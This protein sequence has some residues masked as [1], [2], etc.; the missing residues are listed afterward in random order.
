[1]AEGTKLGI[2]ARIVQALGGVTEDQLTAERTAGYWS[3][4]REA[5]EM[6]GEDEPV[7]FTSD[8]KP[9]GLGYKQ[10][11]KEPRDLSGIS[12]ERANS[13]AYR[14]WNTH[15]LAKAIIEILVDYI[16][17]DGPTFQYESE[18]V[19]EAL[20]EFWNDPVNDMDGGLESFVRE[21]SLFGEQLFL[22][23]VQDGT[24]IG[25]VLDGRLR[26]GPVDPNQ[27]AAIVTHPQNKRQMLAVRL[28]DENGDLENGPLFKLITA[29]DASGALQ[30][31]RDL[32]EYRQL[33]NT[34]EKHGEKGHNVRVTEG[35]IE[36][37]GITRR[38][39][40]GQ[41]WRLV[42]Q[43]SG[44]AKMVKAEELLK[45]AAFAG[46]C[47]LFQVNKIST[48]VRGRGDLLPMIDW[49]DRFD[50]LFFD[51][52][53]HV[54]LL[55]QFVWDLEVKGGSE[56]SS[57]PETNLI[58]QANKI[59]DAKPN[60]A[61]AHNEN[62]ALEAKNPDL[63]SP[64]LQVL[65][66]QMRVFISGGQRIPEHWIAEGGFTNRATAREMGEPSH[67][68][69]RRRQ[70]FVQDMV[71]RICQYQIDVKVALGLLDAEV[72]PVAEDGEKKGE[73]IPARDAFSITMPDINV[74]DTRAA[75]QAFLNI[76]NAVTRL[77]I[78]NMLPEKPAVE[79]L[80][81]VAELLGVEIDVEAVLED[82]AADEKERKAMAD[83]IGG[84]DKED[85]EDAAANRDNGRGDGEEVAEPAGP[86]GEE[87]SSGE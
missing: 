70:N 48:G 36:R 68:M 80:A 3:G 39:K 12:Q 7:L 6:S 84:F 9:I 73:P 77:S 74:S 10:L 54:Q 57:D 72:Q 37:R 38:L 19:E 33:V 58:H 65:L 83:L 29:E 25:V 2:G 78:A 67:R 18:D 81:I 76:A 60:S 45:N 51:A 86:G 11:K 8:G 24:D 69:L 34:V 43:E 23:F 44:R 59:K 5:F 40:E 82:L 63:K 20:T 62:V 53:E 71:T 17:G 61:Y 47:F 21:L 35:A 56:T 52:A 4:M 49:L 50:D 1:M 27:I 64:D 75:S 85:D 15:P 66:R 22:A 26:L 79:L 42:E 30:G 55:N 13:A 87:R 16:L 41:E 31:Q 28:K 32:A 14:L 46:E